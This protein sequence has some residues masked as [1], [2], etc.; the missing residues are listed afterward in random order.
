MLWYLC[1]RG[2]YYCTRVAGVFFCKIQRKLSRYWF[3]SF[4]DLCLTVCECSWR[5]KQW[6]G[7][8][9]RCDEFQY[10]SSAGEGVVS[11]VGDRSS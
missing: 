8:E 5:G 3:A 7:V 9:E 2:S 1:L 4:Y 11:K 10:G 6:Q